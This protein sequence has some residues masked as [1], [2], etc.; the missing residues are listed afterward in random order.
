MFL[1]ITINPL[2]DEE[3]KLLR[4][5]ILETTGLFYTEAKKYIIEN[6]LGKFVK[7]HGF[8]NFKDY[9]Y[10]LKY[11]PR[12]KEEINKIIEVLTTNETYFFRE[13]NQIIA[14]RDELLNDI[15]EKK[16]TAF[17]KTINIWSA[18][19][20]SGEEPYTIVM[21]LKEKGVYNIND[22][23]ILA[24]DIS[25]EILEK[26]KNGIYRDF[27]FRST[28]AAIKNKYFQKVP[29]GY[30]INDEFKKYVKYEKLNF[31]DDLKM[32]SKRNFDIIFCRNVLIYFNEETK[33]KV[34][35]HF[36]N[37][38]NTGGIFFLGHSETLFR[39]TT[40]FEIVQFKNAIGYIKK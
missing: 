36:Y 40:A 24:T 21:A 10:F 19:C 13:M 18:A 30:K 2:T 9:Y 17:N 31:L 4:D 26:A 1:N 3:F 12:R 6:R 28:D 15:R 8:T 7:E 37:S 22:I 33:K 32:K 35:E 23:S 27:S 5:F 39:T 38:L 20:S 34:I 11:D 16:K 25:N 29:D 14:F